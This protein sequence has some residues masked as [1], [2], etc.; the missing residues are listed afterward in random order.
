M[1]VFAGKQD[2]K[3]ELVSALSALCRDT[4][5]AGIV[6][7]E[8]YVGL[9]LA[10]FVEPYLTFLLDGKKTVES[11]FSINKNAPFEQ[12]KTGDIVLLKRSSGPI[13][14]ACRVANVWY[15]RL[16]PTTWRE[17]ERYSRA[18]CMDNSDF[19][20]RKKGASFAT[21]MQVEDVCKVK[22]FDI[23]KSDPRSW[24]VVRKGLQE[25]QGTL[26]L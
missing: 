12:V 5:L 3:K 2:W 24:V 10:V 20:Q 15:Y 1:N 16:D 7:G 26:P 19:W 6:E 11:R 14:G 22:E 9:H 25:A 4:P 17:I 21:L 8:S 18:L 23:D 13:C